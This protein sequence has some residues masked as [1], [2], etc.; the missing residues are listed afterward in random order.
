MLHLL[1]PVFKGEIEY[2]GNFPINKEETKLFEEWAKQ[3][4]PEVEVANFYNRISSYY[5]IPNFVVYRVNQKLKEGKV[6]IGSDG[7][8]WL[9]T[10]KENI[11]E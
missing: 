4:Y 9:F 3:L 7:D 1:C 11:K 2:V 5:C 10:D 8:N 6:I